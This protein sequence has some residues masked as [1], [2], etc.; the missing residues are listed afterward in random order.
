[1]ANYR[2]IAGG[3]SAEMF[4]YDQF[5]SGIFSEGITAQRISEDLKAIGKVDK[6]MIRINSIGGDVME[7][8]AIYSQLKRFPA[9]KEVDIDG[10]ALSAAT[11][12]AMAGD[13]IRMA[14]NAMFMIHNPESF[15]I[16]GAEDMRKRASV[17]DQVKG[18]IMRT[19]ATKNRQ[20]EEVISK[21]MDEE[22]WFD[23]DGALRNGFI[24]RI[25]G[26]MQVTACFDATKYR[27]IPKEFAQRAIDQSR[28]RSD[29]NAV[30]FANLGERAKR[31]SGHLTD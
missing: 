17:L 1:M 9:R 2:V 29:M 11:F 21:M 25:T 6:L 24:D 31:I 14:G 3:K 28:P 5:G 22:T 27:N 23:A 7:A 19:Y 16:G 10:M 20:D 13:E 26:P 30:R 18:N 4:L 8:T 15:A 12:V